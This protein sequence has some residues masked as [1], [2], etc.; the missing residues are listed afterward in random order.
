[1]LPS[2]G[3]GLT[4][5]C[6][7]QTIEANRSH[8][9]GRPELCVLQGELAVKIEWGVSVRL[10][11]GFGGPMVLLPFCCCC[12]CGCHFVT[13]RVTGLGHLHQA[14]DAL[15]LLQQPRPS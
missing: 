5:E 9:D 7:Y 10:G 1:M 15:G 6:C 3:C 12:C 4:T 8:V 11:L 13:H 2:R 14:L